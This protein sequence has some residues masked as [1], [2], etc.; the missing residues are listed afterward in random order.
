MLF[1]KLFAR[2]VLSMSESIAQHIQQGIPQELPAMPPEEPGISHAPPRQQVLTRA[3][4][5]LAIKNA[6]RYFPPEHHATLAPEFA[7]ELR[8]WGRIYMRRFRPSDPMHA[9]PISAYPAR[10]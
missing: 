10:S 4:R 8:V 2:K 6:L 1:H 3:E 9:R 7:E 5:E